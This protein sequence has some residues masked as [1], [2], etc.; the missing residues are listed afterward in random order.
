MFGEDW[1][2]TSFLLV[3]AVMDATSREEYMVI[4]N[5]ANKRCLEK[6]IK[7]LCSWTLR[8]NIKERIYIWV[9]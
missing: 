8:I 6:I 4:V 9:R 1:S 2:E 3:H 7:H 5:L